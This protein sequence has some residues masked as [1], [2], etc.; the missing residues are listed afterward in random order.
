MK[1]ADIR[2]KSPAELIKFI[3]EQRQELVEKTRSL[4]A[5]ELQNASSIKTT[6]RTIATAL[7]VQKQQSLAKEEA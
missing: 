1:T 6:R 5:G 7:T 4:H 3:A 2:K